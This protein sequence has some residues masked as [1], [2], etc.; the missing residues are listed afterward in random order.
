MASGLTASEDRKGPH[1]QMRA[2][3]VFGRGHCAR[4]GA[5]LTEFTEHRK[6]SERYEAW[7]I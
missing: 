6:K 2:F 7:P 3:V 5:S 1:K 4:R